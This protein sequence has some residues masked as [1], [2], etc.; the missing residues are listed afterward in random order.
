[1][2]YNVIYNT[3]LGNRQY[4]LEQC[5]HDLNMTIKQVNQIKPSTLI[6]TWNKLW[7][8]NLKQGTANFQINLKIF[9]LLSFEEGGK[10]ENLGKKL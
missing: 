6:K 3:W 9:S 8:N 7:A 1:M 5:F 10:L 4:G 2:Q